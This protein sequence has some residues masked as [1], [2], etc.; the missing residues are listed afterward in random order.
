M[1]PEPK[2]TKLKEEVQSLF[3]VAAT[4]GL[5]V[6]ILPVSESDQA[7]Y[8]A[9]CASF[10][11]LIESYRYR[12]AGHPVAIKN[13]EQDNPEEKSKLHIVEEIQEDLE[14]AERDNLADLQ[15]A[16]RQGTRKATREASSFFPKRTKLSPR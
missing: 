10:E 2:R 5:P 7:I 3:S 15:R 16:V 9:G 1:N 11:Q 12:S 13:E 6:E 14:I 8:R 4:S